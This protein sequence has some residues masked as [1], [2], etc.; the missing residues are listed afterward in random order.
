MR[1]DLQQLANTVYS[2]YDFLPERLR[3]LELWEAGLSEIVEQ[4]KPANLRWGRLSPLDHAE[5][6][7]CCWPVWWLRLKTSNCSGLSL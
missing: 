3:A 1:G 7:L 6:P 5:R 4:R 2:A